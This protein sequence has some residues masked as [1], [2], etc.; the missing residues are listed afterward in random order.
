MI[1]FCPKSPPSGS[2]YQSLWR[3]SRRRGSCFSCP[4]WDRPWSKSLWRPSSTLRRLAPL[5]S[6]TPAPTEIAGSRSGDFP[7]PFSESSPSSSSLLF[8]RTNS[9]AF[10]GLLLNIWPSELSRAW[11]SFGPSRVPVIWSSLWELAQSVPKKDVRSGTSALVL[12]TRWLV[13]VRN[14]D[15]RSPKLTGTHS[16]HTHSR[17]GPNLELAR[18]SPH[19]SVEF[20][21]SV[22]WS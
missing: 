6:H 15:R 12:W 18:V 14:S 4:P 10:T 21:L 20:D 22:L 17:V 1:W 7:E 5:L 3:A 9:S 19:F 2:F 8:S 11:Q 13:S 16:L